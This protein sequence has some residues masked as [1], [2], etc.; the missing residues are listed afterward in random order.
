MDW[1]EDRSRCAEL[2]LMF[3]YGIGTGTDDFVGIH[4]IGIHR[5]DTPLAAYENVLIAGLFQ[6]AT[7]RPQVVQSYG[8][9]V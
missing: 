9:I 4:G 2:S 5:C 1:K 3:T 8:T 7:L 6:A